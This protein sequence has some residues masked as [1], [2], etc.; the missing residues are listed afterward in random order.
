MTKNAIYHESAVLYNEEFVEFSNN[1]ADRV[2]D[3]E[4]KRWCRAIAKQHEYHADRHKRA[5][6]KMEREEKK[7]GKYKPNRP[8]GSK[9]AP[10]QDQ[11]EKTV[12]EDQAEFAARMEAQEAQPIDTGVDPMDADTNGLGESPAEE[13]QEASA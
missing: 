13:K 11:N 12:I 7:G 9:S 8:R 3:P 10:T 1:L 2:E 6:R 4:I 5:L